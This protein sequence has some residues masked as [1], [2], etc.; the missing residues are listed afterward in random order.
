MRRSSPEKRTN[1]QKQ[2]TD[3]E[4]KAF[5]DQHHLTEPEHQKKLDYVELIVFV[6]VASLEFA[7][8]ILMMTMQFKMFSIILFMTAPMWVLFAEALCLFVIRVCK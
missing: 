8:S 3:E 6:I 5:E 4:V 7:F 1:L 2:Y